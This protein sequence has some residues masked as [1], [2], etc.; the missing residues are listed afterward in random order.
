MGGNLIKGFSSGFH[1]INKPE[2]KTCAFIRIYCSCKFSCRRV[3]TLEGFLN[4]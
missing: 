4:L 2:L 1:P 3:L